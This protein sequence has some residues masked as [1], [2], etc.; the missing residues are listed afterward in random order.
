MDISEW[1]AE[2]VVRV[3]ADIENEQDPAWVIRFLLDNINDCP[4]IKGFDKFMFETVLREIA[5]EPTF[6]CPQ[7][8]HGEQEIADMGSGSGFAGGQIYWTVYACGCVD[9]DESNDI[10][11]AR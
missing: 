7:G 5:A 10:A 9:M 4:D 3:R 1:V 11:A 6:P 8:R 2:T